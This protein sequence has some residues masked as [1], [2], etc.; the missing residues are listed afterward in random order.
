MVINLSLDPV[1]NTNDSSSSE[2]IV[3]EQGVLGIIDHVQVEQ[4]CGELW[5]DRDERIVEPEVRRVL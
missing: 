5:V 1:D 4:V 3:V 2:V